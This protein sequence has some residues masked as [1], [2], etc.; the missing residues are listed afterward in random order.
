MNDPIVTFIPGRPNLLL[1]AFDV[2]SLGSFDTASL[3]YSVEEFFVAGTASSYAPVGELEADGRWTVTAAGQADYV[4]RIVVLRPLDSARFNGTAIVEWLNVTGGIDA[5]ADW[6]MAHREIVRAGYAYVAVS[7][8]RVG[9]EGGPSRGA[10]MSLKK[11]D[12]ERYARLS[13]PG[14]AFAYD[15]FSQAGRLVRDSRSGLLGSLAPDHVLAVGESQSAMFLTTYINAVDPLAKVY[16]GFLVHSRFGSAGPLDGGSIFAEQISGMPR[17]PKFRPDARVPILT[18]ITETDLLGGPRP[19]Y[20]LARQP[21]NDRLRTWDIAGTAH[22]DNYVT[23][24]API[25]SGSAPIEQLAA[26]FAPTKTLMG[27]ELA[28]AINFAPQ[29]HYV[30]QAALAALHRWVRIGEVAPVSARLELSEADP[31]QLV[32]DE[33]GLA[34]GGIRTPWVDV[35]VAR[36]SGVGDPSNV[37]ASLFGSGELFDAATLVRLYPGGVEDYLARFDEAL[38]DAISAGFLLYADRQE[39]LDLARAMYP[40]A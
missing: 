38:D 32:L 33:Y 9:V 31:P 39:I 19:G 4:T 40:R 27:A 7:V 20:Y 21:D 2:G 5:P 30:V 37:M 35:P 14:D 22:A 28:Q 13:H 17:A 23:L 26:A 34:K 11:L 3:G 16:D 24:V 8:Q 18:V 6:F 25:D 12:P 36:T 15:I 10:D 1:G 29:H